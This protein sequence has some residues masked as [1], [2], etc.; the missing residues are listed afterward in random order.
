MTRKTHVI[1][2]MSWAGLLVCLCGTLCRADGACADTM[3]GNVYNCAYQ[4]CK[5]QVAVSTPSGGDSEHYSCESV[6]CCKQ[7][8]SNC[9]FDDGDCFL[10]SH[11]EVRKRL[12]RIAGTSRILVADC[13]GRYA[14]YQPGPARDSVR[15]SALVDDHILR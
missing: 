2:I 10:N 7:L 3:T 11:P 4:G 6:Q 13:R 5:S 12:S 1:G 8:F 14:L 9:Y 15:H